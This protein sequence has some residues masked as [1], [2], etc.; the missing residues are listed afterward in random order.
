M[1]DKVEKIKQE[2]LKLILNSYLIIIYFID[3]SSRTTKTAHLTKLGTC[4]G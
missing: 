1:D 2:F 3:I 4:Q